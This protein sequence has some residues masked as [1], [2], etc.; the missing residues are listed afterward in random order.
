MFSQKKVYH[1][2]PRRNKVIVVYSKKY[3]L[4]FLENIM[5]LTFV[6]YRFVVKGKGKGRPVTGHAGAKGEHRFS[7]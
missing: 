1:V 7:S 4:D 6:F 5:N 3:V 2:T